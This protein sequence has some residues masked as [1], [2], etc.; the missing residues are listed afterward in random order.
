M[1]AN[2]GPIIL[3]VF[4]GLGLWERVGFFTLRV[5]DF[6]VYTFSLEFSEERLMFMIFA[7]AIGRVVICFRA[8]YMLPQT[9]SRFKSLIW[10]FLMSMLLLVSGKDIFSIFWGWEGVGVM[11]FL[12]IGW[13][14]SRPW[15]AYGAKKAMLYN[16]Y[17]DFFG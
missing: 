17:T 10:I 4:L 16:R 12:L 15:A 13:F 1:I 11:S 14:S 2:I 6:P 7:T 8:Y 9:L 3:L 5:V